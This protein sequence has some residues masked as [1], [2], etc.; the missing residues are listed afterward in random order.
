MQEHIKTMR[1][2]L[3]SDFDEI[4]LSSLPGTLRDAVAF[5]RDLGL[6]FLRVG[7]LC[8]IQNDQDEWAHEAGR[9]YDVYKNSF[10]MLGALWQLC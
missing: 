2:T 5:T 8:I 10:V 3:E 1:S 9:M 6:D 7:S 4:V